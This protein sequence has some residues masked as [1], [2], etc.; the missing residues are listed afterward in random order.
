MWAVRS[1][2]TAAFSA[3]LC[4]GLIL[5]LWPWLKRYALARPNVRSSH[6]EPTPQGG[7]IA[8]VAATIAGTGL[9]TVLSGAAL[10][11]PLAALFAGLVAMACIGAVDDVRPVAVAPRLLFEA[12]VIAGVIFS[13]PADLRVVPVLPWWS[14]R[15]VLF[16]GA[17]WFVNLVNFMDGIDWM[18]VAEAVPI[19]AA[20]AA[21][22]F[23][24]ALTPDAALSALAL[25]GAL[26]GF[27]FFNRPVARL[28]LGDVGSLPVGLALGWILLMLAAGGHLA[29]AII[30]PLYFLADTGIT[31]IWRFFKGEP[32][33]QAHRMHFYQIA[34]DR[35]FSVSG[36]VARVFAVNVGLCALAIATVIRPGRAAELAMLVAAAALVAWLLFTFSRGKK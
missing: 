5:L 25:G 14:E 28:F 31:L 10:A 16:I 23:L 35:G 18:I 24:G 12:L 3:A 15:L 2:A 22:G 27:A 8:V 29:A 20:L 6:R 32:V 7:G 33:L 11:T 36:I 19:A 4:A 13:L 17:I 21:L 34:T 9:G 30:M 26:I 1:A